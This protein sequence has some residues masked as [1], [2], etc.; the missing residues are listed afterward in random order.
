[1]A[2]S[3]LQ[4]TT[5]E[6]STKTSPSSKAATPVKKRRIEL[7]PFPNHVN[8]GIRLDE[9]LSS[10]ASS[11]SKSKFTANANDEHGTPMIIR[12]RIVSVEDHG[13]IVDLGGVLL[14]STGEKAKAFL[15]F[16]NI[17]GDYEIVDDEEQ[18]DHD[19]DDVMKDDVED[20]NGAENNPLDVDKCSSKSAGS[21]RLLNKHRVFDFAILPPQTSGGGTLSILQLSLPSTSTLATFRTTSEMVPSLS[22]LVPGMLMKVQVEQH[23]KNG[24]CV[25]FMKGV[26]RGALDEDHLGGWRGCDEKKKKGLGVADSKDDPNMWW[27]SVFRGK[28]AKVRDHSMLSE[29]WYQVLVI[30]SLECNTFTTDCNSAY[31]I[32]FLL[33]TS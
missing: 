30:I 8:T 26:Y 29:V 9:F 16:E 1:M 11:S 33:N 24:M 7:S 14:T 32:Y 5:D 6:V 15:K 2:F 10:T 18:D 23:A 31:N 20:A 25:S 3:I 17:E 19:E 28:H 22:S 4:T 13:C 27:K 21:K 12:G